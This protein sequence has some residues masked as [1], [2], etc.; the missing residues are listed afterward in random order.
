MTK[1]EL[2]EPHK[3]DKR[4]ARRSLNGKFTEQ[5]DVGQSVGRDPKKA[6]KKTSKPGSGDKGDRSKK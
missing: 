4:L 2:I 5:D 3:G 1:R 6:A